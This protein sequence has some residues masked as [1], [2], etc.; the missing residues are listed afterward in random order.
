MCG[1]R[2]PS[3]S[4]PRD[5]CHALYLPFRSKF[6]CVD[7][8]E[9]GQGNNPAFDRY[10]DIGRIASRIRAVDAHA[11]VGPAQSAVR[12]RPLRWT[13]FVRQRVPCLTVCPA[14]FEV[15]YERG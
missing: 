15:A 4:R 8:N 14:G 3:I 1:F 5:P 7:T 10:C 6:M 9:T 13:P 11:S 2:R 12:N